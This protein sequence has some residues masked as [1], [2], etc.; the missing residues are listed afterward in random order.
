MSHIS[1]LLIYSYLSSVYSYIHGQSSEYILSDPKSK[2]HNDDYSEW[3]PQLQTGGRV[4]DLINAEFFDEH[5]RDTPDLM[6]PPSIVA[7]YN[8]FDK[9]CLSKYESFDFEDIVEFQLPSRAWLFAA[10]YDIGAAPK[11]TWY[12]FIPE[13]DLAKRFGIITCPSFVIVPS[14]CNGHTQ[15]C[16]REIINS[17]TYLGCDEYIDQC[18]GKYIIWNKQNNTNLLDWI[19]KTLNESPKP[20]LGG[21]VLSGPNA[22]NFTSMRQQESWLKSRD[23]VTQRENYRSVWV[24]PALPAFSELGYKVRVME[25][26]HLNEFKRFHNKWKRTHR[27]PENTDTFGQTAVNVHEV[28]PFMVSLD[29]NYNFR[30]NI[31]NKYIKPILEEWVGFELQLT[32]HYGIREYY[33]GASLK[34]HIDRIDVLIISATQSIGHIVCNVTKDGFC[35]DNDYI[36]WSWPDDIKWP[37]EGVDFKGNNIR[38][39]H[40]PGTVILYESAKFIHGRPY[41]LPK[42]PNHPKTQYVHLGSFCHFRPADGSWKRIGHDLNARGNLNRH[43]KGAH[44]KTNPRYYPS[45]NYEKKKQKT[46]L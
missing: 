36:E 5:L 3:T 4:I 22:L 9:E 17:V 42:H 24:A 25:P 46:E 43:T 1:F 21:S 31:A 18:A 35:D 23:R 2:F 41:K 14:E 20:Q 28:E 26:S 33:S 37:L 11:R 10:K 19:T 16:Q 40:K 29:H 13:R 27:E 7:F 12:K 15:W 39:D 38:Y 34:N 30:D 32:S 6:R 45:K 8:S 44:Y